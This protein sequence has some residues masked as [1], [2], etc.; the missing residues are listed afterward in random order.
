MSFSKP[1]LISRNPTSDKQAKAAP[2]SIQPQA[3]PKIPARES[4]GLHPMTF[5]PPPKPHASRPA[6]KKRGP[7]N[8]PDRKSASSSRKSPRDSM[9]GQHRTGRIS[10]TSR[11]ES[12]A[13]QSRRSSNL[14]L[15]STIQLCDLKRTSKT[16]YRRSFRHVQA[17]KRQPTLANTETFLPPLDLSPLTFSPLLPE[18]SDYSSGRF[19]SGCLSPFINV[20][21]ITTALT[22]SLT[23]PGLKSQKSERRLARVPSTFLCMGSPITPV[24]PPTSQESFTDHEESQ[25]IGLSRAEEA[26]DVILPTKVI[27]YLPG[28]SLPPRLDSLH[29]R[30]RGSLPKTPVNP[31]QNNSGNWTPRLMHRAPTPKLTLH[32]PTAILS[33]HNPIHE[34]FPFKVKSVDDSKVNTRKTRPLPP[35]PITRQTTV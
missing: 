34:P 31:A 11:D 15:G 16:Q 6:C 17:L 18:F 9:L 35:I 5:S 29:G 10:L 12:T 23:Q 4:F 2:A 20:P 3:Q 22:A 30:P 13:Q 24:S 21:N 32:V 14:S 19:G 25:H 7:Q 8:R 27:S 26:Q 33:I 28:S 1:T